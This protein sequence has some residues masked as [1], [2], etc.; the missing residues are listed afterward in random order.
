MDKSVIKQ[1]LTKTFITEA[2]SD[3]S[4]TPAIAL[5]KKI[6]KENGKENKAGIK[7]IAT[8][9]DG[10]VK[11]SEKEAAD[12]KEMP[13]NK[14]NAEGEEITYHNEMEI[15]NGQEMIQYDGVPNKEFKDRAIEA[16]EG[17]ARMGN[18]PDY[19][20]VVVK[21]W[22]ADKDFG[23]KLVKR[24]KDSEKKRSDATPTT[25][26]FG[27]DWEVTKDNSHK[28]YAFEN[29]LRSTRSMVNESELDE[30]GKPKSLMADRHYT[31]FAIYKPTNQIMNAWNYKGIDAEELRLAPKEYF[32]NDL[33]DMMDSFP[34]GKINRKDVKIITR[35]A[36]D[37][38][39]I[40]PEDIK[41]W[42]RAPE[43]KPEANAPA[44][45]APVAEIANNKTQTNES[46]KRLKFKKEFKGVGNALKLIPESYKTDAKVFEMTDGNESYR[47]R[48][49]GSLTEGKAIIL[50]AADKKYINEDITRMKALFN[51]KSSDTLGTV[52]GKA[53]IDENAAFEDIWKKTR[54]LMESDDI[55][56]APVVTTGDLDDAVDYAKEAKKDIEGTTSDDDGTEA[57]A[58]KTSEWDK[59]AKPQAKEAKKHIEGSTSDAKGT[60]APKPKTGEWDKIK[61]SAPEATKDIKEQKKKVTEGNSY[62]VTDGKDA[63]G[64]DMNDDELM[65]AAGLSLS[66][67]ME[68]D[69]S[70]DDNMDITEDIAK[71]KFTA[72]CKSNG[73]KDGPS[74]ACAKKAEASSSTSAHKMATFY[75]NTVKP[76]GKTTKDI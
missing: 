5:A 59:I 40:N 65:E 16:I 11:D 47:I 24:I 66:S 62:E 29:K 28:D 70:D 46:M 19:A 73:F 32:F 14:F 57:P 54:A 68:D 30:Y 22:G 25:K 17:S 69:F 63:Y 26:M 51:Y 67:I 20:N 21:G 31:H 9:V 36:L 15:M 74:I 60:Q 43:E 8:D 39:G 49:E 35:K 38:A 72:W 53:R 4:S 44:E 6:A 58:P 64:D 55:E 37:K 2:S 48:W 10:Y 33:N 75:M 12:Q 13:Q 76:H 61:K 18:S 41:N 1:Y 56:D 27:N 23:K 45:A 71:G 3:Q 7:A 50:T 42:Y 34:E 52:K